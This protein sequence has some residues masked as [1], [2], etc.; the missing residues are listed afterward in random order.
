MFD[1]L[2]RLRNEPESYRKRTALVVAFS[3]TGIVFIGW[4]MAMSVGSSVVYD[5]KTAAAT[6]SPFAA[7]GETVKVGAALVG[8]FIKTFQESKKIIFEAASST[9]ASSTEQ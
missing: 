3:L 6:S 1:Y 2:E 8:N 4:L 9:V 5:Q 7:V